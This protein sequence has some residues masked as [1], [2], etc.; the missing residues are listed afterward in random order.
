MKKLKAFLAVL[1][2]LALTAALCLPAFAAEAVDS[3]KLSFGSDGKFVILQFADC[4]DKAFPRKAMLMEMEKALAEV[5]PDLVVFTGDN[6]GAVLTKPVAKS[7]IEKTLQPVVD[8]GVPFAFVFGNH[9]AEHVE[10]EYQLEIYQ[11]IDGCLAY[12]ADPALTGCATYNLPIYSSTDANSVAFNLWMFDSNMYDENDDYDN[13]HQDQLDWYVKTSNELKAANGGV[14]VPSLAFQHIPVPEIF[15]V[16]APGD[17]ERHG[18]NVSFALDE[19]KATGHLGE[20]SCP[21]A[22]NS[23]Q[24]DCMKAQGDIIG[25]VTGHDHVNSFVGTHEGIDFIQSP[26]IGFGTY[27][28]EQRGCRVITL[29]EN[30]PRSYET[31]T[32][33]FADFFGT[34]F[35]AYYIYHYYGSAIATV[36]A[37]FDSLLYSFFSTDAG[38]KI[39]YKLVDFAA[40]V[41]AAFD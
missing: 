22:K 24:F 38:Q 36:L 27:G 29:N 40:A 33:C 3:K 32:Y 35:E 7:G 13:V 30:N 14:P 37:P 15:A 5:K 8:A 34:D 16:Y 21:P 17:V 11:S 26:G 41:E 1:L 12:D 19:T 25:L 9:D 31:E 4:Q 20:W 23:G 39:F 2:C 28:D 10:K 18:Y 6:I